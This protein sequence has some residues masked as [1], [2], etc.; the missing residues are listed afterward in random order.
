MQHFTPDAARNLGGPDWLVARR[1]AAAEKLA[2]V[3][4]PT[5][6]DE[7]W[8]YSR[9][10]EL[11]LDKYQPFTPE[12]LGEPGLERAPGGGPLAAEA[13]ERAGLVVVRDGRVVHHELDGAL[14]A[15][16]VMVCDLA[17]C[18]EDD[19]RETLG[20]CS[21]ASPDAFTTLHDAFLSGGA[22]VKVPA[23]VVVER[24]I[25]VLHWSE[26]EGRASFPHT[27]VVLEEG[28]EATIVE[29]YVSPASDHLADAVVELLV[30]DGAH[31]KYLSLQ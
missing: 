29:R 4:W 24:P 18:T 2:A 28:S 6:S 16:G 23:G 21:D 12:S 3:T 15:K 19:V 17:T 31:L 25:V 7:I 30:G 11:D 13:G 1:V 9:I 5:A 27:L 20:V 22:V 26:G 8:R 10:D 14:E